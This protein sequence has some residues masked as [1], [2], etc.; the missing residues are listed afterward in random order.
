MRED[1]CRHNALDKLIGAME[2][3][4][5]DSEAGFAVIISRCSFEMVQKAATLR[6]PILVAISAPATMALRIA[7]R[8]GITLVALARLD[9]VTVYTNPGRISGLVTGSIKDETPEAGC[10]ERR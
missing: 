1:V 9:S 5:I 7:E 6:I 4:Q 3:R 2:H 10:R 8:T